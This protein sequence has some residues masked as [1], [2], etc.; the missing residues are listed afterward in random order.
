MFSIGYGLQIGF[1]ILIQ[2]KRFVKN[3]KLIFKQ[4]IHK[5]AFNL[6]IF[7][8]G[9]SGVYRVKFNFKI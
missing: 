7:L 2:M 6:G 3:P 5:D 8:G 1:R 4:F 9:F